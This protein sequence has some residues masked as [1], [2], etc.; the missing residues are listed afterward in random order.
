MR[1]ILALVLIALV[2]D[3]A[4][5]LSPKDRRFVSARHGLTVEAP[6]GWTLSTHTGFPTILLLLLHPDG[7]RISLAASETP[8][9]DARALVEL[10]RGALEQQNM[11]VLAIRAGARSGIQVEAETTDHAEAIVQL[12]IVRA[13]A[14]AGPRQAVVVSLISAPAALAARRIDLDFVVAR[15]GL[16]PIVG[17]TTAAAATAKA[18]SAR[19]RSPEKDG[20]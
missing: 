4:W 5:A 16:N 12:Y 14:S 11:K 20:R 9:S 10:N 8:A 1:T 17:P 3:P 6:P 19:E 15:L 2:A 7:S 13:P 18:G